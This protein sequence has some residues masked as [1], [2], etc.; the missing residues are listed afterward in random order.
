LQADTLDDALKIVNGNEHGNGT[1]LFTRSGP[2]ARKFQ[3]EV[4]VHQ[5]VGETEERG[6]DTKAG[7][8]AHT[9]PHTERG[10]EV[11]QGREGGGKGAWSERGTERGE[12]RERTGREGIGS[13]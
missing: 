12:K 11:E 5:T 7:A 6:E 4:R 10:N 2:A 1:A 13:E 8:H 3:N 9:C